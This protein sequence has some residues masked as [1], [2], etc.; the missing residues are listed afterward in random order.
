MEYEVK[1]DD[2]GKNYPVINVK[3]MKNLWICRNEVPDVIEFRNPE[4]LSPRA[5][6]EALK[7]D[8][9]LW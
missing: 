8:E 7:F 3:S 1:K 2:E 4:T 6:L 5:I 9:N